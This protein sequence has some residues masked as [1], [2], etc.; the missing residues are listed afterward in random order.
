MW[1]HTLSFIIVCIM[2]TA[3][4]NQVTSAPATTPTS[5]SS[6]V[7][8]FPQIINTP[9]AYLEARFTGELVLNNGC[10]RVKDSDGFSV[11]LIW[12]PGFST[13][14]EQGVVQ[15]VDS[16]G[17]VTASVGDF[18]EVGG[19][20]DSNPTSYGLAEPLPKD[21]PGSYWLVGEWIR[22]IDRP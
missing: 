11:L 9:P 3:C 6:L 21:C 17:Q 12:R 20:F 19:G 16:T 8:S 10:L 18:V 5:R 14:T 7:T 13:R 15:I 4:A 2:I 22:K 1:K